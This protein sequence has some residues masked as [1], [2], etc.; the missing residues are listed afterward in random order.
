MVLPSNHPIGRDTS[1]RK[2]RTQSERRSSAEK[3]LLEAARQ[4]LSRKGWKATTLADVGEAAGVSRSLAAHHFG[5]KAGL[6]RKLAILINE[7]F[8]DDLASNAKPS[9]GSAAVLEFV[10]VYMH[11]TDPKWTS[12]RTVLLLMTEALTEGSE[13]APVMAAYQERMFKYLATNIRAAVDS[14]EISREIDPEMS[15]ELVIGMLRGVMLQRLLGQGQIP[16]IDLA[17]QMDLMLDRW[18]APG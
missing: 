5:N 12:T 10:R 6:L 16:A 2:K 4:I 8:E 17:R 9:V 15:A 1:H 7:Q 18:F 13:H 11:R 14:G 3:A